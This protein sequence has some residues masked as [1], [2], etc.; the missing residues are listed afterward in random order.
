MFLR[1]FLPI[2][3]PFQTSRRRFCKAITRDHSTPPKVKRPH[4]R[5]MFV[6]CS[7]NAVFIAPFKETS[8]Q[9]T[10][11]SIVTAGR[12]LFVCE[13]S[14]TPLIFQRR[15]VS[16]CLTVYVLDAPFVQSYWPLLSANFPYQFLLIS[17]EFWTFDLLW[18]WIESVL[19]LFTYYH[20]NVTGQSLATLLLNKGWVLHSNVCKIQLTFHSKL[21]SLDMRLSFTTQTHPRPLEE[22]VLDEE[23]WGTSMMSVDPN[24]D[25]VVRTLVGR[26]RG[27]LRLG[28]LLVVFTDCHVSWILIEICWTCDLDSR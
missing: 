3:D 25:L 14:L 24:L 18:I 12:W 26:W 11:S 19:N 8:I 6:A 7:S 4:T 23:W 5:V 20:S 28:P 9:S 15:V 27:L 17:M 16:I 1:N 2:S 13:L 21:N 22:D 10:P